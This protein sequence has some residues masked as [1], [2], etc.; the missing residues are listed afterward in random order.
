MAPGNTDDIKGID[1]QKQKWHEII[2]ATF[3]NARNREQ[4]AD[5]VVDVNVAQS[6]NLDAF[7]ENRICVVCMENPATVKIIPCE[8]VVVCTECVDE[9]VKHVPKCPVCRAEVE[10][11]LNIRS[12]SIHSMDLDLDFIKSM[13]SDYNNRLD[14][15]LLFGNQISDIEEMRAENRRRAELLYADM[16]RNCNVLL[17]QIFTSLLLAL[18]GA[19][20]AVALSGKLIESKSDVTVAYKQAIKDAI[21]IT[22][23]SFGAALVNCYYKFSYSIY[24]P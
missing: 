3:A 5:H 11:L 9:V 8:H 15:G 7:G 2:R 20:V 19:P 13:T 4:D 21:R 18:L 6:S 17:F 22:L 10:E 16:R 24:V 12:G 23:T 1:V 14:F